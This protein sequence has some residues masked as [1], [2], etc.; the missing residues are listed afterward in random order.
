MPAK[1]TNKQLI[2]TLVVL[3]PRSNCK[4]KKKENVVEQ[5]TEKESI[6]LMKQKLKQ[7]FKTI[8]SP[9]IHL[10]NLMSSLMFL[11]LRRTGVINNKSR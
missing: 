3:V 9:M 1:K 2:L 5:Q 4:K 8:I 6:K 7:A 10:K 11:K